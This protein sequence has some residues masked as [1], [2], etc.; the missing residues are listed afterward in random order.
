MTVRQVDAN[1][2][3]YAWVASVVD[4]VSELA[5]RESER[6]RNEAQL[7]GRES[8]VVNRTARWNSKVVVTGNATEHEQYTEAARRKEA[9]R[10][11]NSFYATE[12]IALSE[13]QVNT[14]RE[15]IARSGQVSSDRGDAQE[16]WDAL[17]AVTGEVGVQATRLTG[18]LPADAYRIAGYEGHLDRGLAQVWTSTNLR[19]IWNGS[20]SAQLVPSEGVP[21]Q[22]AVTEQDN[23]GRATYGP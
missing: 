9:M 20:E 14:V 22:N 10:G 12:H 18:P 3:E 21:I 7:A 6:A 15:A 1:S 17:M 23:A 4:R 2:P 8:Q 5:T 13:A 11:P 19:E 16:R